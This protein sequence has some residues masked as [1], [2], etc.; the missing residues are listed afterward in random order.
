MEHLS[1]EVLQQTCGFL[2]R[3]DLSHFSLINKKCWAA[4]RLHVFRTVSVT[5]SSPTTLEA[6]VE[7][8]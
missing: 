8:C 6:S 1:T 3:R 7:R 4:S 2:S 5:F